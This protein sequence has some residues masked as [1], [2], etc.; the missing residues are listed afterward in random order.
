M[1][2]HASRP[3]PLRLAAAVAAACAAML[4]AVQAQ[5]ADVES[6]AAA[7]QESPRPE[8]APAGV[9]LGSWT[10]LLAAPKNEND[11]PSIASAYVI[12]GSPETELTLRGDAEVRRAGTVIKGEEIVYTQ[13]TGNVTT[14]GNASV[15]RNGALF[16]APEFTYN[17]DDETGQA[18]NIEYDYG[19][20][21]LQGSAG[22]ARFQP[23]GVTELDDVVVTSCKKDNRSW[24]IEM[25]QLTLD[26]YEQ[27]GEGTGAVLKLGG[28]PVFGSPWFTFP[29]FCGCPSGR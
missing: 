23:A 14:R 19:P 9:D 29:T 17:L 20:R 1:L 7:P 4:P 10:N 3:T 12:E 15:A 25:D 16:S 18:E 8:A 2:R 22:C 11:A 27:S 28:V 24:W 13:A 21:G 5:A 26:E 6:R